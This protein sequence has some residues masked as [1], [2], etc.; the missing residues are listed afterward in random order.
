MNK[1]IVYY[2][3]K[4]INL[5]FYEKFI[6]VHKLIK[7]LSDIL[8]LYKEQEDKKRLEGNIHAGKVAQVLEGMQAAFI[9]IGENNTVNDRVLHR[10]GNIGVRST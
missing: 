7:I 1:I 10:E 3:D 9:N 2:E 5:Q 6:K 8:E 4:S